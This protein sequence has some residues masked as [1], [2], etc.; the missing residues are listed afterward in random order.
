MLAFPG[1]IIKNIVVVLLLA[2]E[3]DA[4]DVG[5]VVVGALLPCDCGCYIAYEP[6]F[7]RLVV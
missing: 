1:Q 5:D 7:V 3:V 4:L 2:V 6:V